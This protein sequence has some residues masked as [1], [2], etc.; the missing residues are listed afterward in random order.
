[1]TLLGQ[2]QLIQGQIPFK[3]YAWR[4]IAIGGGF[5]MEIVFYPSE[6]K[7]ICARADD[8]SKQIPRTK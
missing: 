3:K 2:Y 7:L 1:L 6:K 4:N 5:V 8:F